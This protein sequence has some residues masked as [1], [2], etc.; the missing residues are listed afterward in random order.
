MKI[1]ILSTA[2]FT[3]LSLS[4]VAD[5]SVKMTE[6][7]QKN[8]TIKM[9]KLKPAS[10]VAG[11]AYPAE[12]VIPANQIRIISSAYAGLVDQVLVTPGLSVKKGQAIAYVTSPELIKMQREYLQSV[13]QKRL[14]TQSLER[15]NALF[16][17]GI[18]AE[19]R[20]Q[21]TENS[22]VESAAQMN[23]RRQLLKLAGME[24]SAINHLE[25]N[26]QYQNRTA[27]VAPISG[28]VLE[29]T[30]AQGQRIEA[31]SPLFKV[32]Q[33]S[34]LWVE[35]RVPL[36]DIKKNNIQKGAAARIKDIEAKGAVIALLPNMRAQDQT[37][38]V[39]VE[40]KQGLDNLFPSQMVDVILAPTPS[41]NVQNFSIPTASLVN[42]QARTVVFV[43]TKNGFYAKEV[44]LLNSQGEVSTI[45]GE[46]T[47]AEQVVV[48]GTAA[49]KASWL[50]MGG[51]E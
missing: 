33:L 36:A 26:N 30:A 35:V 8:L 23:E 39:R 12:V 2:L 21:A 38:I 1:T 17:D 41:A 37:A 13:A 34:P 31:T 45:A 20:Q 10:T 42:H 28:V 40:I 4:A 32:A 5:D 15:D 49:I 51:A 29:Q 25:K 48:S 22:H 6:T 9:A 50:G 44:K 3:L 27:L 43:Q 16:K 47:G 7:R 24:E 18:I 19:K 11:Q 46:F 14:A